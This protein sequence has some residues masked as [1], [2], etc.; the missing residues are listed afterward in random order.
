[1][2]YKPILLITTLIFPETM[3]IISEK[4]KEHVNQPHIIENIYP[5][6]YR[7]VAS[8]SNST[9]A[10]VGIMKSSKDHLNE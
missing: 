9:S 8:Y 3:Q 5:I 10:I 6:A 4:Y 2:I 1:M 7:N